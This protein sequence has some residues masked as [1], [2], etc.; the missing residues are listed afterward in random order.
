MKRIILLLS[1]LIAVGLATAQPVTSL[2]E[3]FDVANSMPSGWSSI[4]DSQN[5]AANVWV[6]SSEFDAHSGT[7]FVKMH[8]DTDDDQ[9]YLFLITPELT[10]ISDNTLSFFAKSSWGQDTD[11][12]RVGSITN[13]TDRNTF[14]Q[15]AV[16]PLTA[17]YQEFTVNYSSENSDSY[18]AFL[19]MPLGSVGY[20]AY[21]DDVSWES[22][23]TT[24]NPATLIAPI[25]G[26]DDV[27][28]TYGTQGLQFPLVWSSNGGNPTDYVLSVGTDYPPTNI[29]NSLSLGT[30]T[31]YYIT[32]GLEYS[33]QYY[34]Q[35]IPTNESGE[36]VDC[37]I[38]EFTTMDNIV[39]DFNEV[40]DYSEGFEAGAI[41][42]LPLGW[43]FENVNEDTSWWEII[44]NS[45]WSA[46]AHTGSQAVHIR[47]SF[48]EPHNDWLYSPAMDLIA[49]NTYTISFWYKNSPF[50]DS[51]EKMSFF[52]GNSPEASAMTTELWDNDNIVNPD[53]E[54]AIVEYT[55]TES[56]LHFLGWYAYSDALQMVLLL[57]D[58]AVSEEENVANENDI[59]SLVDLSL[60][61]YPNPFNPET[62]ISFSIPQNEV[63]SLKIYNLKGQLVKEFSNLTSKDSYVV[64]KG[65]NNKNQKIPSGIYFTKLEAGSKQIVKKVTLLK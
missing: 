15:V 31:E 48:T 42:G 64:W 57:D 27:V 34:W 17:E 30:E 63:G 19:H 22:S 25:D 7:N 44:G 37:P 14:T 52:I 45:D 41:G 18:I 39:I 59:A 62:T 13:P 4:I 33:T 20:S 29:I 60:S 36:A 35:V 10:Q 47:F 65:T 23:I 50:D 5:S 11:S 26:A 8:G 54:Q 16:F 3:S 61:N 28:I 12:L 38:W 46:N 56:G 24:P 1:V 58:V 55:P 21:I 51:V 40:N 6:H 2:Y 43:E 9:D 32:D 49:G 53:Y